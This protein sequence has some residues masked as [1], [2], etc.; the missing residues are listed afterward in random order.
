MKNGL[1]FP[2][3][4][5]V[6]DDKNISTRDKEHTD[7]V[8]ESDVV[9]QPLDE[10][11]EKISNNDKS[12]TDSVLKEQIDKVLL[13]YVNKFPDIQN[14]VLSTVD[15]FEIASVLD[16]GGEESI[17]KVSA[18][19]SSLQSIGSAILREIGAPG[20]QY[21]YLNNG[22]RSV[23]IYLI[24]GS[25]LDVVLMA[26]SGEIDSLGQALWMMQKLVDEVKELIQ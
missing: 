7:K 12:F 8:T 14:L 13:N 6:S 21:L 23:F 5:T 22:K 17:R 10:K 26:V 9:L 19:S 1:P 2:L 18:M 25:K 4:F 3:R 11:Q 24:S 16:Q 15:G 20:Y